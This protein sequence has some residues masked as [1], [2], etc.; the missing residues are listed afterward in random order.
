M[1]A[2]YG[3]ATHKETVREAGAEKAIVFILS[4]AGMHGSDEAIRLVREANPQIRVF[5]RANYLREVPLLS[6]AGADAVF[7]G[8]GE[9]ALAMNEFLL[10]QLGA[11]EEQIDR[12]TAR[13]REELFGAPMMIEL[14][15]P[16]PPPHQDSVAP[17]IAPAD[18]VPDSTA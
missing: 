17:D 5:A 15:A 6:H 3:D 8:E 2:V 11:S 16:P 13:T 1:R 18:R 10:R 7:S 4:S 9:I 12:Q 14:L